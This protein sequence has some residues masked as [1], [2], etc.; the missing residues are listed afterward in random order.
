MY[1]TLWFRPATSSDNNSREEFVYDASWRDRY[2]R[3]RMTTWSIRLYMPPGGLYRLPEGVHIPPVSAAPSEDYLDA[4]L[5]LVDR[6]ASGHVL[7]AAMMTRECG[8]PLPAVYGNAI[9]GD[10][11]SPYGSVWGVMANEGFLD[12]R[13]PLAPLHTVDAPFL[14]PSPRGA[15][16]PLWAGLAGNAAVY[17]GLVFC[18]R[19]LLGAIVR[20]MRRR[21][22]RCIGCG[23]PVSGSICTECG[24][25]TTVVRHRRPSK[26]HPPRPQRSTRLELPSDHD[27]GAEVLVPCLRGGSRPGDRSTS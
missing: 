22:H 24:I 19:W 11:D 6:T 15:Y 23:H 17:Y 18:V 16:L 25:E 20:V 21:Q 14:F 9:I 12:C 5:E 13:E 27:S 8:W 26:A 2:S 7:G 1:R 10:C 3:I 4:I